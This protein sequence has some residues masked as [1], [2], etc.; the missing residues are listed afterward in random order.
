MDFQTSLPTVCTQSKSCNASLVNSTD[1]F[2]SYLT[3][4]NGTATPNGGT[5]AASPVVAAIMALINDARFRA[6]QPAI[7]FANPWLYQIA[8]AALNDITEGGSLGCSGVD[9]QNGILI[10]QG[11]MIPYASWNATVGW[12][13]VT[14]L[15]TPDFMKMKNLTCPSGNN[16]GWSSWGRS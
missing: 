7:G 6:G 16:G 15:G 14:G 3:V 12:D 5:S 11:G 4:I 10:P 8:G 2:E 9:L 1:P 13:P